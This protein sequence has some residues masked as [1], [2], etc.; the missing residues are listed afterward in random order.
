MV[1]N[2]EFPVVKSAVAKGLKEIKPGTRRAVDELAFEMY[3]DAIDLAFEKDGF[4]GVIQVSLSI[5]QEADAISLEADRQ[6]AG[7][8]LN[9]AL[10]AGVLTTEFFPKV[11]EGLHTL[12]ND[13]KMMGEA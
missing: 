8:E 12:S 7:E 13:V 6:G 11:M 9:R 10:A 5:I 4:R 1:G 2:L 3:K